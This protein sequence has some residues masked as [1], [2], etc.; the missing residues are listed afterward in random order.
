MGVAWEDCPVVA[1]LLGIK[2]FLNE[3]VAYQELSQ[4]KQRR[5]A[6]AEEWVG[7]KKQWISVSVQSLPWA[8]GDTA[9]RAP[10][11][12]FS[13]SLGLAEMDALR[14]QWPYC[15]GRQMAQGS[16]APSSRPLGAAGWGEHRLRQGG[17]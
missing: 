7:T 11:R 8:G 15:P 3:F 14:W 12:N 5:L 16:A 10:G 9:L 2:L 1:E 17:G 6:G 4:Y 13:G